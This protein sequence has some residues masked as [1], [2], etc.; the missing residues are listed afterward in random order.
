M[1]RQVYSDY[2]AQLDAWFR[3]QEGKVDGD[4]MKALWRYT[5]DQG[6]NRLVAFEEQVGWRRVE[7]P[8]RV[9]N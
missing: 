8:G 7:G 9:P 2:I 6:Q 1:S 5:I 4:E 3:A